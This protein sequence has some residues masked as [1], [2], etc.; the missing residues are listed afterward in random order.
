M[1]AQSIYTEP[2]TGVVYQLYFPEWSHKTYH[3]Y[4]GESLDHENRMNYNDLI[5]NYTK[6]YG[7]PKKRIVFQITLYDRDLVKEIIEEVEEC[8]IEEYDTVY[9]NG[10]NFQTGGR[11]GLPCVDSKKKMSESKKGE[12]HP[13]WGKKHSEHTIK[14]ISKNHTNFSGEDHPMFG[15]KHSE[16]SRKRISNALKGKKHSEETKK[17]MSESHKKRHRSLI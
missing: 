6:K 17:K 12:K 5:L 13:L 3:Y 11:R 8:F 4:Y 7:P 15:K 14:K 9:P 16:I 10:L 2:T 1:P